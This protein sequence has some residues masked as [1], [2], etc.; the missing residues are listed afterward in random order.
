MKLQEAIEEADR[1]RF[2]NA[3]TPEDKIKWLSELDNTIYNEVIVTHLQP[4][5]GR[6]WYRDETGWHFRKFEKYTE[7]DGEVELIAPEPYSVLYMY[8]LMAKIDLQ[9]RD[10]D[11][12]QS[13]TL[14]ETAYSRFK[15]WYH[16]NHRAAPKPQI[17]VWRF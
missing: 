9:A 6:W 10:T 5:N 17:K 1:M 4:L 15:A 13:N 11:Y 8:W 16:R 7:D 2:G 12:D 14:F 3:S